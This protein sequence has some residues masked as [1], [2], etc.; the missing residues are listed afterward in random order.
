MLEAIDVRQSAG[1]QNPGHDTSVRERVRRTRK[2]KALPLGR[3]GSGFWRLPR[4]IGRASTLPAGSQAVGP[5]HSRAMKEQGLGHVPLTTMSRP[6]LFID[7]QSRRSRR[8]RSTGADDLI[9]RMR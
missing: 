6:Q 7:A 9:A 5:G 3:K 4:A 1:D 8:K 2:T